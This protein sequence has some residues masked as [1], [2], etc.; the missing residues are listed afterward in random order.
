MA[1]ARASSWYRCGTAQISS[2]APVSVA[3]SRALFPSESVQKTLPAAVAGG[4]GGHQGCGAARRVLTRS[5]RF[6]EVY[7]R[8]GKSPNKE[9]R[10]DRRR[11]AEISEASNV[12]RSANQL[13]DF[14]DS[15][16]TLAWSA[17]TDGTAESFNQR[18]LDYTGLSAE[19]ARGW[20]WKAAIHPD[21]LP[22]LLEQPAP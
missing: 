7:H 4:R 3:P 5:A 15:I 19:E 9:S 20:G 11:L 10:V 14:I 16:P 13:R 8:V 18:W 2:W 22:R 6:R 17:A 12:N 21:D 1:R